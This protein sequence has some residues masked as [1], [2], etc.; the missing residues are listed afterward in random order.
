[1]QI[2]HNWKRKEKKGKETKI[3]FIFVKIFRV[4][5]VMRNV[6]ENGQSLRHF[7]KFEKFETD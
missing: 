1:M 6:R 7:S 4:H 5:D 3:M 2:V